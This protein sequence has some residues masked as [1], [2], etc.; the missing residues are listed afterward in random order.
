MNKHPRSLDELIKKAIEKGVFDNL[1]GKGKPLELSE[2]PFEDPSWRL[3][4]HMLRSSGFSLPWIETRKEIEA[5]YRAAVEEI[6][7]TWRWR[8]VN[9]GDCQPDAAVEGE[10]LR[11][12]EIFRNK[13]AGLNKRIF[14]YNLEAPLE[15]FKLR[16]ISPE[17]EIARITSGAD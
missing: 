13:A 4:N 5:D 10:W 9:S 7:R 1:P 6:K 17:Q 15:R 3:A 2:N 16:L 11:A 8:L 12:V 14:N